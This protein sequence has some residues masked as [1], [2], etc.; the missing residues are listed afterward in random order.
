MKTIAMP[1][2]RSLR[3]TA[4]SCA[5]SWTVRLE[6]GSSRTRTWAEEMT[7]ARAMAAICWMATE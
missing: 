6:V 3:M 1:S 2:S 7:S 5:V 4:K